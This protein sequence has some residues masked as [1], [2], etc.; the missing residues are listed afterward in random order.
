MI[1]FG[2]PLAIAAMSGGGGV[3]GLQV[4]Q[5]TNGGA[6]TESVPITA[7]TTASVSIDA[8]ALIELDIYT[9]PGSAPDAVDF[10]ISG[11]G[12][13]FAQEHSVV[14][15]Q[16]DQAL[17]YRAESSAG[18]SGTLTITA[19]ANVSYIIYAVKQWTGQ[20]QGN[21]GADAYVQT[22]G[23]KGANT[24][25]LSALASDDNRVSATFVGSY[26]PSQSGTVDGDLTELSAFSYV[27]DVDYRVVTAT[28]PDD[29]PYSITWS[30]SPY[31]SAV[32]A[33][34]IAAA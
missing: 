3:A 8:G 26:F 29:S 21:N 14:S 5:L 30:N 7:T 20:V 13:T 4:T 15:S 1:A 34:E 18:A 33:S 12:L 10:T 17:R 31:L 19:D 2:S 16:Y 11:L 28:G 27:P 9:Y 24:T 6:G 23:A 25:S 32:I 22:S